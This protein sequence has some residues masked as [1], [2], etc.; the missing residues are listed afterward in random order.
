VR[1]LGLCASIL[2]VGVA[3]AACG[4]GGAD[5]GD[6]PDR[7]DAREMKQQVDG[8]VTD[9]VPRLRSS[10]G[11]AELTV[12]TALFLEC[13]MGRGWE[14]QARFGITDRG[15]DRRPRLADVATALE[16]G[17]F[18]GVEVDTGA[19]EVTGRKGDVR[20]FV[21]GPVPGAAMA[22]YNLT[23]GVD[24]TRLDDDGVAFARATAPTKFPD[25][26]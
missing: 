21:A 13:R 8:A 14:Y 26:R 6:E 7:A 5:R 1:I 20:A 9:L 22:V 17:G 18:S 11:E 24:C 3:L 10:F 15:P 2:V 16:A 12:P 19:S 4:P 25:L 23:I